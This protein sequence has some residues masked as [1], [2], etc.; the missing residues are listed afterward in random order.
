LSRYVYPKIICR[1]TCLSICLIICLSVIQPHSSLSLQTFKHGPN[2]MPCHCVVFR[3]DDVQDSFVDLAQL[4]TMNLF[5]S[6][7]QS[8]TLG[9]IMNG[10]GNDTKIIGQVN[11]GYHKGLFE[12]ALHGWDHID[13]TKL[14]EQEQQISLKKAN[15]KMQR[16]FGNTSN[17]FIT[18][19]GTFNNNTIKAMSQLGIRIL[20]AATF[21][22]SEFDKNSSV[23]HAN[24]TNAAAAINNGN[25]QANHLAIGSAIN[26]NHTTNSNTTST[27]SS[28]ASVYHL[29][30][31]TYFKNDEANKKPVKIPIEQILSDVDSNIKKY[32]YVIIVFHPQDFVKTDQNGNLTPIVDQKEIKDLSNLINSILSKKIPITTMSKLV[33]L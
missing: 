33:G 11:A 19:Y 7:N 32:G 17:I 30:A 24:N 9:L 22:E 18:P 6:N 27:T 26:T 28:T 20:S 23:F 3:M 29:P 8:L 16:L 4:T 12:L 2:P 5:I 13:Y 25:S 31:M 1:I 14:S 21:S 15:D 10:I